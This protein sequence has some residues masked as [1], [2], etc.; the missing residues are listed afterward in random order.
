VRYLERHF[1]EIRLEGANG[2][3]GFGQKMIRHLI[4]NFPFYVQSSLIAGGA[5]F[6][7][8]QF[9]AAQQTFL[10]TGEVLEGF[11]Q[12]H[13]GPQWNTC[14]L[15]IMNNLAACHYK[16]K[17]RDD[18]L[19]LLKTLSTAEG[20]FGQIINSNLQACAMS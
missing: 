20:N 9:E 14:W 10:K 7:Q 11:A 17:R 3:N 19:H 12:E 13:A 4:I 16:L 6:Q 5:Q 8:D 15:K 1:D 2:D 18:A